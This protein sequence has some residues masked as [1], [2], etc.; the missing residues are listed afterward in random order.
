MAVFSLRSG[1]T[2]PSPANLSPGATTS[3]GAWARWRTDT[4][5]RHTVRSG[6]QGRSARPEGEEPT[7]Q[8]PGAGEPRSAG[9]R[10]HG[11]GQRDSQHGTQRVATPV[12]LA[13]ASDRPDQGHM[14]AKDAARRPQGRPH[15]GLS[16]WR[17]GRPRRRAGRAPWQGKHHQSQHDTAGEREARA[18]HHR[19]HD[20]P[21][22]PP[23]WRGA[24][25]R[26]RLAPTEPRRRHQPG[27]HSAESVGTASGVGLCALATAL[28][29]TRRTPGRRHCRWSPEQITSSRTMQGFLN[30]TILPLGSSMTRSTPRSTRACR[31]QYSNISS[32]NDMRDCLRRASERSRPSSQSVPVHRAAGRASA[33]GSSRASLDEGNPPAASQQPVGLGVC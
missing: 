26:V 30:S 3:C 4:G 12:M 23:A 10:D 21:R 28:A 33:R 9:D 7:V 17:A 27:G 25:L 13:V 14:A 18:V 5:R 6:P 20:N 16:R 19:H 22:R 29:S 32:P 15:R 24:V 31:P 2:P 11:A 1:I 8:V